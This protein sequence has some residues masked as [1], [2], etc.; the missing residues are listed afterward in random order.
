MIKVTSVR[1]EETF[2][3]NEDYIIALYDVPDEDAKENALLLIDTPK[4]RKNRL[5]VVETMDEL[6]YEINR[7]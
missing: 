1:N 6:Y 3:I 7:S 4:R 2:A 5:S